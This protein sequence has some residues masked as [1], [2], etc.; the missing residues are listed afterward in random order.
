MICP[1]MEVRLNEYVDDTLAA[2]ERAAVEA[3]LAGCAACRAA[4]PELRRLIAGARALPR[5]V[6]PRRDLWEEIAA[7]I[8]GRQRTFWRGALAAAAMLTLVVGLYRL[9]PPS[10]A[11]YHPAVQGWAAV[12]ADYEQ[13]T[14]ELSGP[15]AAQRCRLR[16]GTVALV[17]RNLGVID[18]AIRE[19]RAALLRDPANAE[20][21]SLF[22][23]ASRQKVELLRWATR[24]AAS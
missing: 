9:L 14:Q 3:H 5:S 6:E 7:R 2:R 16:P 12:Q 13:A 17:A 10:T 23:A 4:V 1:E 22:A 15:L 20:I 21:E 24:V 19:S 18:G 8:V 11:L